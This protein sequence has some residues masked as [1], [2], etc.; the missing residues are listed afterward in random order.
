MKRLIKKNR[1]GTNNSYQELKRGHHHSSSEDIKK[2]LTKPSIKKFQVLG[3]M[4]KYIE[5]M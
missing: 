2:I 5:K 4:H 1:E 3:K